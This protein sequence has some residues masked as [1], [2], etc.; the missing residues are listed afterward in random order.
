MAQVLQVVSS[1]AFLGLFILLLASP[2]LVIVW[3][4]PILSSRRL[5]AILEHFEEP[6]ILTPK[7]QLHAYQTSFTGTYK[8]FH[9]RLF[10]QTEYSGEYTMRY[11]CFSVEAKHPAGPLSI[12]P[13]NLANQVKV[14]LGTLG[15]NKTGINKAD[16]KYIMKGDEGQLFEF[17]QKDDVEQALD[18]LFADGF[19]EI[20]LG[21]DGRLRGRSSECTFDPA[22]TLE[23]LDKILVLARRCSRISVLI[24]AGQASYF[25]LSNGQNS[26]RCPYC[27]DALDLKEQEWTSCSACQTLHHKA[28]F[29]EHSAC[30]VFGCS[31]GQTT[32][33]AASEKS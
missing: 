13:A 28:C 23:R 15:R 32:S 1:L 2:V 12:R 16:R 11:Q 20:S 3:L 6:E 18:Q 21:S 19:A 5:M 26:P 7:M 27:R 29:E 33:A 30:T 25:A 10:Y 31:G 17:V 22:K 9:L 24:G 14:V 8:G 4:V